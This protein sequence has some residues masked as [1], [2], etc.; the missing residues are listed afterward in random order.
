MSKLQ[1]AADPSG[2]W[3]AAAWLVE[4]HAVRNRGDVRT[5]PQDLGSKLEREQA[6]LAVK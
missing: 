3:L 1:V 4:G 6:Y 5:R 2:R